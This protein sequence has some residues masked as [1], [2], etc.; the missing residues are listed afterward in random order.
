MPLVQVYR[1]HFVC[2]FLAVLTGFLP[3]SSSFSTRV[4]TPEKSALSMSA[5]MLMVLEPPVRAAAL[6][7][8][9]RRFM[10]SIPLFMEAGM[11]KAAASH[12]VTAVPVHAHQR[13][14]VTLIQLGR[15]H[16]EGG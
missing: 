13:P 12:A 4:N 3:L 14:R 11:W 9:D 15:L 5:S 1:T 8:G 6:S 2:L 7:G 16:L 10:N